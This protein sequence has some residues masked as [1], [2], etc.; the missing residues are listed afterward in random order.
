MTDPHDREPVSQEVIACWRKNYGLDKRT[1]AEAARWWHD[2]LD[3]KAPAGCVAALGIA[4]DDMDMLRAE[5]ERLRDGLEGAIECVESW[6]AYAP[7]YFK[8]KHDLAG[9]LQ[10]LRK[11]LDGAA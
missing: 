8:T 11:L 4:L 6:A 1:P 7:D 5:I 10:R 2:N 3:R 9:E